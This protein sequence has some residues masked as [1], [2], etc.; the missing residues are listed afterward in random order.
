M[1]P[2]TLNNQ[3]SPSTL[4]LL[5][6][7]LIKLKIWLVKRVRQH[8]VSRRFVCRTHNRLK[9]QCVA[10]LHGYIQ[11]NSYGLRNSG[12]IRYS[13]PKNHV[14]TAIPDFSRLHCRS[15]HF[16]QGDWSLNNFATVQQC[17]VATYQYGRYLIMLG[18]SELWRQSWQ[19]LSQ[20]NCLSQVK[21]GLAMWCMGGPHA[22][23]ETADLAASRSSDS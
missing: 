5:L 19:S 14:C 8:L 1:K 15:T 11:L 23:R 10:H 3:L 16:R 12:L 13:A 18:A 20:I 9:T 6:F 17:Y 22:A 7:I 4:R 21:G 2:A